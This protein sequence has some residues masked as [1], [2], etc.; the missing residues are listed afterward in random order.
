MRVRNT[1]RSATLAWSQSGRGSFMAAG[2]AAG[3]MSENFDPTGSL[4][5]YS[6]DYHD[7]PWKPI[8]G[9]KTENKVPFISFLFFAL[10]KSAFPLETISGC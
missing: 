2:T 8:A 4:E 5:I 10:Y 7:G 9:I 6:V 3:T 1:P